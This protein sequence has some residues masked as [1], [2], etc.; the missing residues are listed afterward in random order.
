MSPEITYIQRILNRPARL[1]LFMYEYIYVTTMSKEKRPIRFER[2]CVCAG[3]GGVEGFRGGK[4]KKGN[5]I[6]VF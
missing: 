3:M 2:E 5:D 1:H 6:I 4:W